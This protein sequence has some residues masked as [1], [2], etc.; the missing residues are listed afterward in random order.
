MRISRNVPFKAT[1]GKC[2]L[3]KSRG[4]YALVSVQGHVCMCVKGESGVHVLVFS[5]GLFSSRSDTC[6]RNTGLLFAPSE[7]S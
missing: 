4:G 7:N 2:L 5:P 1:C 3:L 6:K